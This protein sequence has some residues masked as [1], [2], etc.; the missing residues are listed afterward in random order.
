[1]QLETKTVAGTMK[2]SKNPK[3]IE[4]SPLS[5]N[6]ATLNPPATQTN[7]DFPHLNPDYWKLNDSITTLN[8]SFKSLPLLLDMIVQ[9]WRVDT[10]YRRN[11]QIDIL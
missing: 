10:R 9:K 7:I 8:G 4:L 1:M 5:R 11:E 6:L 2:S 3:R